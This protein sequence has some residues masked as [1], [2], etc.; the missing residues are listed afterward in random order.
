MRATERRMRNSPYHQSPTNLRSK[1]APSPVVCMYA[2]AA[3]LANET[4]LFCSAYDVHATASGASEAQNGTHHAIKTALLAQR[5]LAAGLHKHW[6]VIDPMSRHRTQHLRCDRKD[7]VSLTLAS[8]PCHS[9]LP[10]VA[11][12][13][14][15]S[16]G[17]RASARE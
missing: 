6:V 7:Q 9:V 2:V 10:R 12:A 5:G 13:V 15:A 17:R 16:G 8:S 1:A 3:L 14:T 11:F 4:T